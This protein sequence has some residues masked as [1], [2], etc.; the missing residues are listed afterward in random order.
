[1]PKPSRQSQQSKD[2]RLPNPPAPPAPPQYLR[3]RR[4]RRMLGWALGAVVLGGLVVADQKGWLLYKGSEI[5]RYDAKRFRV[6]LVVD[7]DTLDIVAIGPA[8]RVGPDRL[9][10]VRLWGVDTPELA[11]RDEG[12]IIS[13]AQPL[14]QEATAFTTRLAQGQVVKLAIEPHQLRGRFGR[15]LAFVELPDG[16]MLNEQLLMAGLARADDRFSHRFL[17]RFALLEFQAKRDR[18]GLWS[19]NVSSPMSPSDPQRSGVL[20]IATQDG[21]MSP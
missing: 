9:T 10:R 1:M 8:T 11:K 16:T 6:T 20:E 5:G 12:R 13:P 14:A 7:G 2:K 3:D 4:R 18:V 21:T 17:E 19:Q 15:L